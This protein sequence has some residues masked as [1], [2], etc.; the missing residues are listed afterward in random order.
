MNREKFP[1]IPWRIFVQVQRA[2]DE[3]ERISILAAWAM[4]TTPEAVADMPAR[5]VLAAFQQAM[6]SVGLDPTMTRSGGSAG[7]P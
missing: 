3:Y 2:A 5:D 6:E 7:S 4:Q 1:D